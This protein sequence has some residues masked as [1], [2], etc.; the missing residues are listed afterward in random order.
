VSTEGKEKIGCAFIST[1]R[2]KE[3]KKINLFIF[4]LYFPD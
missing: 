2:E 4:L 3:S 1:F